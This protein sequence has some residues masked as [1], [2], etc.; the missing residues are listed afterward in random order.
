M[1]LEF[2]A[3]FPGASPIEIYIYDY[4]DL[5]GDDLIGKTLIDLD[6]REFCPEWKAL[7]YKPIEYRE[8]YHPSTSLSQGS[9]ICWVDIFD[10]GEINQDIGKLWD[11][12]P[13][14]SEEYELRLTIYDT[15]NVPNEDIEGTSDVFVKAWLEE[16]NKKETE[17]HWRCTTGEASLN[18][19]LLFNFTSP[20]PHKPPEEAYKLKL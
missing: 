18:Y 4:D 16:K 12:S 15:K 5:F 8:L 1:C 17:T 20:H 13:E 7:K 3:S 11:L 19:R 9:V 6:D 2:N 10:Q 14:P